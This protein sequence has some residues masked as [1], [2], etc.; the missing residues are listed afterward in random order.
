[1]VRGT[2]GQLRTISSAGGEI[3]QA[4]VPAQLP[5]NPALVAE[6]ELQEAIDLALVAIGRLDSVS[7]LLPDTHLFL[8][9]YVRQEA[10][11]S[12]QIEGTQSTLSDLLLFELDETP[13]VPMDVVIEVSKLRRSLG[14]WPEAPTRRLSDFKSADQ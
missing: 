9:T 14:A 2:T 12:S 8:Y 13:G 7:T 5:P 10:V 6:G 4:F 3:A 1:M 11:L